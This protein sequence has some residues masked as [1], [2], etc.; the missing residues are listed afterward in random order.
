MNAL[1]FLIVF[2]SFLLPTAAVLAIITLLPFQLA[3]WLRTKL[4]P[5]NPSYFDIL[6]WTI[7]VLAVLASTYK[8]LIM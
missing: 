5:D 4:T 2:Y 6:G 8:R 1:P 3:N 7:S